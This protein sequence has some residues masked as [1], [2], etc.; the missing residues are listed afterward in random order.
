M[1]VK[2][3]DEDDG[4][5]HDGPDSAPSEDSDEPEVK[6]DKDSDSGDEDGGEYR[7]FVFLME[8]ASVISCFGRAQA[9]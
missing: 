9:S 4:D 7:R 5:S 3:E 2:K 1:K 8:N 6:H